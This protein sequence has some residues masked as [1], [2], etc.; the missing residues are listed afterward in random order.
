MPVSGA[1]KL[2]YSMESRLD[3]GEQNG[4]SFYING[5]WREMTHYLTRSETGRVSSTGGRV[6]TL[7]VSAGDKIELRATSVTGYL[8][9]IMY[10]VEYIPR[11]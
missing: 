4:C 7:E 9:H 11:M 3:S 2:S 6:L 8:I 1:W 10:C 5:Q